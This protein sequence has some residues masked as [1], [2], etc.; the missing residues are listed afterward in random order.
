MKVL[1]IDID[2]NRAN[3]IDPIVSWAG[4]ELLHLNNHRSDG[5]AGNHNAD[6]YA[7]VKNVHPEIILVDTNSP[8]R[9]VLEDLAQQNR[10]APKTVI[11]L[12]KSQSES[13]NRL[14][15]D[16]GIS[17]YAIDAVPHRLL[18][19]LIDVTIS[20]F[21]SID[22]LRSEVQELKPAI[23]ERQLLNKAIAFIMDTYGLSEHQ[24]NDLLSKNADRQQRDVS[25]LARQLVETGSFV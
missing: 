9:D 12:D 14:A 8:S 21:H 4:M 15:A 7:H 20:H 13:I 11:T 17:L 6:I 25:E 1:L 5:P 2:D 19:A 23:E 16:V 10:T 3:K 18:Q 22:R 24:A